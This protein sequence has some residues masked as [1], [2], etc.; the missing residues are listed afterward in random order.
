LRE[1]GVAEDIDSP[2]ESKEA[3]LLIQSFECRKGV[4][5]KL[6]LSV[7]RLKLEKFK[8]DER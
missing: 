1:S 6:E 5:A 7:V 2:G 8:E 3:C 4:V